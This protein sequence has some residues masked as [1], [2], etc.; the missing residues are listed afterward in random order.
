MNWIDL[1]DYAQ[2]VESE[3]KWTLRHGI[4]SSL[5]VSVNVAAAAAEMSWCWGEDTIWLD[6][7][8]KYRLPVR[9]VVGKQNPR[10]ACVRHL[11]FDSLQRVGRR[12]EIVERSEERREETKRDG[13]NM[14]LSLSYDNTSLKSLAAVLII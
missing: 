1:F 5:S 9:A 14:R 4:D 2:E 7:S 11:Q 6:C 3:S 8:K 13:I 12:E 10:L